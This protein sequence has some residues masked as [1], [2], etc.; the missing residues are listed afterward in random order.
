MNIALNLLLI[1][2]INA[3]GA[4]IATIISYFVVYI[5]RL[6]GIKKHILM[7]NF[8]KKAIISFVIIFIISCLYISGNEILLALS[9]VFSVV[10]IIFNKN[11]II[12]GVMIIKN[13]AIKI[14]DKICR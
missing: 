13:S 7:N 2:V 1:P 11:I 9:F 12:D 10:I 4:S 3:Y 14:K 5:V 8:E 6:I